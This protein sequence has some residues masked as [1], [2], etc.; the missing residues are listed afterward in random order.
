MN[1][2][3]E[4][5]IA[6]TQGRPLGQINLNAAVKSWPVHIV[7]GPPPLKGNQFL[8]VESWH[9]DGSQLRFEFKMCEVPAVESLVSTPCSRAYRNAVRRWMQ[10]QELRA[11]RE[12]RAQRILKS[13]ERLP[14]SQ[15]KMLHDYY[16]KTKRGRRRLALKWSIPVTGFIDVR[17]GGRV[18]QVPESDAGVQEFIN[19]CLRERYSD[20]D[21]S[22]T[23]RID[24]HHAF[25]SAR[26]GYELFELLRSRYPKASAWYDDLNGRFYTRV[27]R[28]WYCPAETFVTL[29]SPYTVPLN[30]G[31]RAYR[32]AKLEQ[33]DE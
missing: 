28:K 27:G 13:L 8:I 20:Y 30:R 1:D 21:T 17:V 3:Q 19:A 26:R 33:Q 24:A 6:L 4:T 14:L 2:A 9:V 32:W 15:Q 22:V 23:T 10:M 31:S 29:P 11:L 18:S 5:E 16:G 25:S 12:R 7:K